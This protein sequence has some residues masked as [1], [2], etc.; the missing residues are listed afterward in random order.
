MAATAG[1]KLIYK[2]FSDGQLNPGGL[3]VLLPFDVGE[4]QDVRLVDQGGN[5]L[6]VLQKGA[7][8]KEGIKYYTRKPG[9]AFGQNVKLLVD[10]KEFNIP[11]AGQRYEGSF[12]G[13]ADL[14]P[15]NKGSSSGP[16]GLQPTAFGAGAA[17]AYLGDQYPAYQP[18]FFDPIP[19]TQ[20]AFQDPQAFAAEYGVE[21]VEQI[22]R[23]Y[24]EAEKLGLRQLETELQGLQ[25][26][27]PA[28]AALKR[29]ELSADQRFN[30]AMRTGQIADVLPDVQANLR[31]QTD[32][33]AS[34]A[35]GRLPSGIEDEALSVAVRSR[36]ADVSRSRGFGD[37]SVVAQTTSD[38]MSAE[39]R[40]KI[41]QYGE[42][43]ITR[44][45]AA[46]SEFELAPTAYSDAGTQVK[47]TP[48]VGAGRAAQAYSETLTQ[49][50][51]LTAAQ[52][53]Q[54]AINQVQFNAEME[55]NT[56]RFNATTGLQNQQFNAQN[57][58]TAQLGA[59]NYN[60]GFAANL[61]GLQTAQISNN[62][63]DK[64]REQ[65][66]A[67]YQNAKGDAQRRETIKEILGVVG[68]LPGMVDIVQDIVAEFDTDVETA[69]STETSTGSSIITS[70]DE[71]II[72]P[73]SPEQYEQDF[74]TEEEF[75]ANDELQMRYGFSRS[76]YER[77]MNG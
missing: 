60:Q 68:K 8:G 34:Y 11:N 59:F 52:A 30:Q 49:S 22:L 32:R 10:G 13:D 28:A 33:A 15:V 9:S 6:E 62:R 77:A 75:T 4:A 53:I 37:N 27:V 58:F 21:A 12:A 45:A 66:T 48:E 38:L 3:S 41:A 29:R 25:N 20:A 74:G 50:S 17:P 43:L 44:N 56:N 47:V 72:D 61:A 31:G 5:T 76:D 7:P 57:M 71:T 63:A 65:L 1:G 54:A 23:N 42:E 18:T 26:F 46:R 64:I 14:S 19:L 24:D 16:A 40:F 69:P 55:A 35:E 73:T 51:T 39:E 67:I 36:A 2:P 70:N